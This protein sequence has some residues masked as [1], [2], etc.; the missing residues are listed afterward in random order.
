MLTKLMVFGWI[1]SRWVKKDQNAIPRCKNSILRKAIMAYVK[2]DTT[3]GVKDRKSGSAR[4][5]L[6]SKVLYRA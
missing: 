2:K 6:F 5:R 4:E 3:V 1:L